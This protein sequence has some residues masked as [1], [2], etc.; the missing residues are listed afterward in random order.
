MMEVYS[1]KQSDIKEISNIVY[2]L[3]GI[4]LKGDLRWAES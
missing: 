2:K 4:P 1:V 3:Q